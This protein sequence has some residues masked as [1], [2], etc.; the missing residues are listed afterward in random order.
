MENI[1]EH[2]LYPSTIYAEKNRCKI[3]TVLGSCISVCLYDTKLKIGGINHYM[4]PLWN[5]EGLASPKYGNIAMEK[6]LQKILSVSY[7]KANII[8]KVFGGANQSFGIMDIG[9]RNTQFA[10]DFLET[11]NIP[12]VAQSVGGNIG[13]KIIFDSFNGEVLMKYLTK[14][15]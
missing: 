3:T 13:R 7:S 9:G 8:A 2:F 4:L 1:E 6:L 11:E 10:F 12:V 14:E 5:G 15:A